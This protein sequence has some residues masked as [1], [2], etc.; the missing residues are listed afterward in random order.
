MSRKL[1]TIAALGVIFCTGPATAGFLGAYDVS[2]WTQ[3]PN[4][5]SINTAGAPSSVLLKG[6]DDGIG[7]DDTEL[8]IAAAASGFVSF[9]WAYSTLDEDAMYDPFGWLLNGVFTQVTAN[10]TDPSQNGSVSFPV[11]AGDVFGF[12]VHSVD[13]L[14]GPASATISNFSAPAPTSVP[15]P[16]S[17]ALMGI[18]LIGLGAL[19][20]SARR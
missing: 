6:S 14:F 10:G 9:D 20:R 16:T 18:G 13:S 19:R 2:N 4:G 3:T 1:V 7:P 11:N 15:E 17:L 12:R 5:G 8:T